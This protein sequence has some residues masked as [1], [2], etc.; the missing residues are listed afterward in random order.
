MNFIVYYFSN[1]I[2]TTMFIIFIIKF[3]L[4]VK[5]KSP[6]EPWLFML[7]YPSIN[8]TITK[9]TTKKK[10]KTLQNWLS[11]IVFFLVIVSIIVYAVARL[12]L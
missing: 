2:I 9:N 8:I 12:K 10:V 6:N 1:I 3:L 4:F 5:Y 7:Y 11:N